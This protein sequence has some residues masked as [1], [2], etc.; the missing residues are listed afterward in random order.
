MELGAGTQQ[1]VGRGM[2]GGEDLWDTIKLRWEEAV[3]GVLL[4]IWE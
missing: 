3:A 2:L 1:Q 4:Q